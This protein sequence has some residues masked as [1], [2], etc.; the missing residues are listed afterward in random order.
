[1]NWSGLGDAAPI[2]MLIALG[3]VLR[4]AGVVNEAG[5]LVLTRLAYY[6]TI[7]A[8][9]FYSIANA[10]LGGSAVVLALIGLLLP[11]ALSAI[12]Y[13][14][15]RDLAE[16]PGLRGVMVAGTVVLGVFGYAFLELFYGQEGLVRVALYDVG[17]A[18]FAGTV[19]LWLAQ[20]ISPRHG[21]RTGP[22]AWRR[23]ATSPV[24]WAAALGVAFSVLRVPVRGALDG[25][26]LRLVRANTPLAMVAVGIFVRPRK[27]YGA[28]IARHLALRTLLGGLLAW[29][30]GA[31]LG[32]GGLD[33]IVLCA[34]ATLP[35]GTTIL[36]Y[37]GNEGLDAEFAATLVSV[38]V[39]IG[40]VVINVLPPLMALFYL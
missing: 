10:Q 37:A 25:F 34:S 38:S 13:L 35:I 39:L 23:M 2:L 36:V 33:M 31:A 8:A 27:G 15:T 16:Q 1:M 26:L 21:E 19:S 5:G 24:M 20:R 9:I 29:G 32:L 30:L 40:A 18:I 6:V 11:I 7:P 14:A 12:A 4:L 17:N 28:L 22:P 3:I